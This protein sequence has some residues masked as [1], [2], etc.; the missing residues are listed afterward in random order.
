MQVIRGHPPKAGRSKLTLF[1]L[2]QVVQDYAENDAE[3]IATLRHIIASGG[4]RFEGDATTPASR[5]GAVPGVA[6][7]PAI[8]LANR[9]GVG[10]RDVDG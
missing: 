7:C 10:R 2:V 4:V 3:S 9:A 1:G 5:R 8:P 6:E